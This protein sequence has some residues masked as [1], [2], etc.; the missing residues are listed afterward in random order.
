MTS[1]ILSH[2]FKHVSVLSNNICFSKYIC[3]ETLAELTNW[4]VTLIVNVCT[5]SEGLPPYQLPSSILNFSFPILD[6]GTPSDQQAVEAT[7]TLAEYIKL[8]HKICIHCKGGHGRSALMAG[9]LLGHCNSLSAQEVLQLVNYAHSI[10]QVMD[11]KWRR[12]GAPQTNQQKE[13]IRRLLK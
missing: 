3:D 5:E 7:L 2:P 4:G 9:L 1:S 13:Q 6:R 10:R 11:S 12:L 8:G